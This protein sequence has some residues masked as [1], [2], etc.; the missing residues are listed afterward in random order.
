MTNPKQS[1]TEQTARK[2][3]T[4][5]GVKIEDIAELVMYLQNEYHENLQI[6]ECLYNVERVLSKQKFKMRYLLVFNWTF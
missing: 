1:I 3:L 4:E 5:R 6:E 2:L